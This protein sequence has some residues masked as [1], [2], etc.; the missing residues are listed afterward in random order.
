MIVTT[1]HDTGDN[2]CSVMVD[3]EVCIITTGK[4]PEDTITVLEA[5]AHAAKRSRSTEIGLLLGVRK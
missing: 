2:T 5:V 3:G 1:V 4:I